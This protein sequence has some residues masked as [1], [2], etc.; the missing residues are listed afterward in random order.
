MNGKDRKTEFSKVI[1]EITDK[2]RNSED[3]NGAL[4]DSL[5]IIIKTLDSEAGTIWL[6]DKGEDRL[7][8]EINV[9]PVDITGLTIENG[10]GIAGTV[11]K[12]SESIIVEDAQSDERFTRSVDDESGFVTK[13]IICVPLKNSFETLGCIQIINKKG[14]GLYDREDL[15]LCEQV[16]SL[17]AI[18]ID[19]KGLITD[20]R[21]DKKVII[22]LR[23]V[24]KEFPSGESVSK[25]LKGINLDI[26]ENEFVCVLGESG[27][28]KSTMVN[29]IGGM[30]NLTDGTLIIEGKDFSHPTDKE[31]T[32]FRREYLG[33]VFQ[34]YNLMPN[35]TAGDNVKFIADIVKDP[36]ETKDAMEKVGLGDKLRSY[37]S[38]LSGGQ[39]QRVSIARAI[40][41]KPKVILADEPT[42]ALDFATGQGV[43]KVFE[44]VVR[45]QGTTV[46][47]ITHN[48][49]IAKMADRVIKL[50]NGKVYSV[51]INRHPLSADEISW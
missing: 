45:N 7:F 51:K 49:E 47:M 3:L 17:A 14:G 20:K 33:F 35:M 39:Q 42:A 46:V 24:I 30:D 11:V 15:S 16:A 32:A 36:M 1:W 19:E 44:D 22:S 27:C 25:V 31:L 38:M 2:L 18:A 28:G 26:Y 21:E 50:K 34:S 29:I 12:T 5:E 43:L 10:Q 13:S 37:P 41:K 40:V 6:L 8:P 48:A 9:G 23:N 4:S